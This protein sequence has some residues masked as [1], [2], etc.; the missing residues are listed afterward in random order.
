[1]LMESAK[2]ASQRTSTRGVATVSASEPGRRCSRRCSALATGQH[3]RDWDVVGSQEL[4]YHDHQTLAFREQESTLPIA[5]ERAAAY[6]SGSWTTT[7]SVRGRR[8]RLASSGSARIL[9][10]LHWPDAG[11]LALTMSSQTEEQ[12]ARIGLT[13][14]GESLGMFDVPTSF[15]TVEVP[16]PTGVTRHGLNEVWLWIEGGPIA[17]ASVIVR[18]RQPPPSVG[19][20]ERNRRLLEER[21]AR[22]AGDPGE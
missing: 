19:Q 17:V 7:S 16:I 10:P 4:F 14:N 1:M 3:A 5:E 21:R 13:V 15:Q 12:H 2:F 22:M 11:R 8:A 6:L 18:D 9:L 20:A